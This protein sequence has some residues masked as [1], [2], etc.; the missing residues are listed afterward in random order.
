MKFIVALLVATAAF[1]QDINVY[2]SGGK[3]RPTIAVPDLRASGDAQRLMAT[4]NQTLWSE[5]AGSGALKMVEKSFYPLEVPQQPSDF[6]PPAPLPH[7][8][9]LT[10]WSRPPASAN[11]LTIGYGAVQGDQFV[12]RG[13]LFNV[14]QPDLAHAQV[15]G[16]FYSGS[17]DQAGAKKV[18]RQ[19]ASEILAQFGIKSLEGSKIY[20]VS[21]RTG[22]KEIWSMD[23][24]GSNERQVTNYK[25]LSQSPVVSPDGKLVACNTLSEGADKTPGWQIRMQSPDGV[26]LR[27]KNPAAP[28]NITPGFSADGKRLLFASTES[29]YAQIYSTDLEGNDLQRVT[30]TRALDVSPRVNP[31]NGKDVLFISDRSGTQQLWRMNIDGGD[32]EML[33]DDEGQVANPSWRPDGQM[34]AFAWTRGYERG[35]FNIFIMDVASRK[36]VQL[37]KDSGIN[38]NPW[39]APDGLHIVFSSKRNGTYQI[40]SMLADGTNLK[41]LTT[42]GNNIQPVWVA[43]P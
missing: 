28:T 8:P 26:R 19:F 7:G 31:K 13:W 36:P 18:A 17:M 12:L 37:T 32:P 22:H 30:N 34:L 40:F 38:E 42:Q 21:D 39:W 43:A 27:F 25:A 20:F 33:T 15:L 3:D 6:K 10:D 9:W 5:L 2:L 4:F 24:D 41:P 35:S 16:R 1:G 29:G 11:Y 14:G 23:Y